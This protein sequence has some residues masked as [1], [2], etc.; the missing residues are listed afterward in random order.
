MTKAEH[1]DKGL[2]ILQS[3]L[4]QIVDAKVRAFTLHVLT[5]APLYFWEVPSSSTGKY[6]PVQSQG[7]G[8]LVRHSQMVVYFA[9]K[10][11]DVYQ[12]EGVTKDCV[13]SAC[14]LH[15]LLK[16]GL[17]KKE[18]TTKKHDYE[19][20]LFVNQLGTDFGLD[21]RSLTLI[22]DCIAWHM[23]RWTVMTGRTRTRVF[24]TDYTPPLLVVHLADVMA[25]QKQ[26]HLNCVDYNPDD[27][28]F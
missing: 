23:G 9:T 7:T 24:P 21:R 17:P 11:C 4:E 15:D 6:H 14:L 22:C 8:G 2:E 28:P 27:I 26:V 5:N 1:L 13:L 10:L 16:Y 25:A 18:F 20:A 3:E 12:V 19:G